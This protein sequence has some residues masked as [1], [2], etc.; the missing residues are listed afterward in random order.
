M[1]L[2]SAHFG[3]GASLLHLDGVYCKGTETSITQCPHREW[4]VTDCDHH[5]D[6]GISCTP[7]NVCLIKKIS[8][9][10]VWYIAHLK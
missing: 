3:A 9:T 2:R 6:V 10:Y 8:W 1:V 5:K 7:G 4:G